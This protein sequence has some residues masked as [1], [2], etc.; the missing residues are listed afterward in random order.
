[1]WLEKK[2]DGRKKEKA[3]KKGDR[4][5]Y[6]DLERV[7]FPSSLS[8]GGAGLD[9]IHHY[10]GQLQKLVKLGFMVAAE[11]EACRVLEDPAFPTPVEGYVVSFVVFDERG[12]IIPPHRFLRSLLR[13]MAFVT[14]CEAYLRIDRELD[15]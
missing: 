13:I 15:Q 2:K 7:A 8:H 5:K 14:L 9:S 10:T 3:R 4:K 11:L 6:Q 1:M 12:F